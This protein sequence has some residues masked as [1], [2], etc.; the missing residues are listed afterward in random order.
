VLVGI[1]YGRKRLELEIRDDALVGA[2]R[3]PHSSPIADLGAAVRQALE[4]PLGFPALNRALTPDDHVAII[5]D[6]ELP[7]AIALLVPVLEH[8]A[9]ARIGPD[10]IT[11]LRQFPFDT[12]EWPDGVPESLR[13][14]QIE[15][16]DPTNRKKLSY[17]ATTKRGRRIYL[18]RTIVDADQLV[19]LSRRRYDPLLGYAGAE[20][21]LYPAMSDE[22]TREDLYS[23]MS[24][25]APTDQPWPTR[26]E[27]SEVSWLLGAPFI[28]QIIEGPAEQVVHII[29]GTTD[30]GEEGI[31]LL[32][33]N[34]RVTVDSE[35]DVVVAGVSGDAS[36]HTVADLAAAFA[37]AARVVK[38]QG[39]IILLSEA[40]PALGAGLELL[41]QAGDPDEGLKLLRQ[42]PPADMASAYLWASAAKRASLYLLSQLPADVADEL[43]VTPL[44]N[45]GQ[46][47]RLLNSPGTQ[48][49]L[50]DAHKTLA[51]ASSPNAN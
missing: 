30:S 49:F 2:H 16:H 18:N 1:D 15:V 44:E 47:R 46:V 3:R 45:E 28:V 11:I 25:A 32:N 24:L 23:H 22:S 10:Q 12:S 48:L 42:K 21:A 17:L 7:H 38:P 8:I 37:C 43:F 41:R 6:D 27:A 5:L 51:V 31:S 20:G 50:S 40:S 39:R 26:K 34:W 14:V 13:R 4:A 29:G 36:N 33:A 35:A 19:V 9:A